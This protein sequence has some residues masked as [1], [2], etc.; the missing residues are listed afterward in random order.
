MGEY[1]PSHY[2]KLVVDEYGPWHRAG[3]EVDPTHIFGQQI[4]MRDAIATALTL[5]IF[6]RHPEK[7]SLG[8]C[9]Q[10]VNNL[11]ALFLAHED[12]FIATPN[13][14][15]FKMY[16]AHQDA[17]AVKADFSAPNIAYEA[18]GKQVNLWG[19][20]GSA[21][22]KEKNLTLTIVNPDIATPRETEIVLQDAQYANVAATVLANEKVNAHNTFEQPNVVTPRSSTPQASA[23]T[24]RFSFPPASVTKL[25]IQMA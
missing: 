23:N 19:L 1:D 22:L 7:V 9:A 18:N 20:H 4:T 13:F 17:T 3:T 10:L 6:N 2:I 16:A 12:K 21:S 8:A 5:D 25:Q 14:H 11:N 15:V 24:L